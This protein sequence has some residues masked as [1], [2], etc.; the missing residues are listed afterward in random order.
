MLDAYGYQSHEI[1][2]YIFYHLISTS[3]TNIYI[4]LNENSSYFLSLN[5]YVSN[6]LRERSCTYIQILKILPTFYHLIPILN[7]TDQY[8]KTSCITHTYTRFSHWKFSLILY[9]I[10]YLRLVLHISPSKRISRT[11]FSHVAFPCLT[12]PPF[13]APFEPSPSF[14][15]VSLY[16]P[17]PPSFE[18]MGA[19]SGV[20]AIIPSGW[21]SIGTTEMAQGSWPMA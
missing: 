13:A 14:Y 16:R 20:Q 15:F 7:T 5:I 19:S 3:Q 1:C 8:K 9:F 11:V 2:T 17:P 10:Q 18:A 6:H 4:F 12:S 21:N